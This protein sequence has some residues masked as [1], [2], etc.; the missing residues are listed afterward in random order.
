MESEHNF[1]F[2][3]I[4]I[5]IKKSFMIIGFLFYFLGCLSDIL[6]HMP[7]MLLIV[8]LLF[9]SRIISR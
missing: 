6:T 2:F 4:E 8:E 5:F 7:H 1:F 3:F 9:F